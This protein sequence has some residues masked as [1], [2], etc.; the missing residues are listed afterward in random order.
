MLFDGCVELVV[1][2][3]FGLGCVLVGFV[4]RCLGCVCLL[5]Y[6]NDILI[7]VI[8]LVVNLFGLFISVFWF[9]RD[10]AYLLVFLWVDL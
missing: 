5:R 4:L 2:F 7:C 9:V 10:V 3:C 8:T 6:I 1:E